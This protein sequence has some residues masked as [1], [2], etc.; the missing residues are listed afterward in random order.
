M[1]ITPSGRPGLVLEILAPQDRF[2]TLP[3]SHPL[4]SLPPSHCHPNTCAAHA[5]PAI[6]RCHRLRSYRRLLWRTSRFLRLLLLAFYLLLAWPWIAA[7]GLTLAAVLRSTNALL[8]WWEV[9]LHTSPLLPLAILVTLCCLLR[10]RVWPSDTALDSSLGWAV[11]KKL[12]RRELAFLPVAQVLPSYSRYAINYSID[13]LQGIMVYILDHP[14]LDN[15]STGSG[16][17]EAIAF[18]RCNT[19]VQTLSF[20]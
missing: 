18:V 8:R 3:P 2:A 16:S 5:T 4:C 11:F 15:A 12:L 19:P 7:T 13:V 9:A 20:L 10:I 17:P 6:A 14:P 1:A